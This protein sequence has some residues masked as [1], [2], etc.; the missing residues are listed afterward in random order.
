[1]SVALQLQA[2]ELQSVCAGAL[3][4]HMGSFLLPNWVVDAKICLRVP[5]LS[6]KE[7]NK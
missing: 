4:V 1:M 6:P 5:R 7:V 2:T 3:G